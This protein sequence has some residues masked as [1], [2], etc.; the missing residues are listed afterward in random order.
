VFRWYCVRVFVLGPAELDAACGLLLPGGCT[1]V[2]VGPGLKAQMEC[3]GMDQNRVRRDLNTE[4]RRTSYKCKK[5]E[6]PTWPA[7]AE[8][9]EE[10]ATQ[11]PL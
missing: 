1:R 5:E 11:W 2:G 10:Q 9:A 6:L 4:C 7:N 8:E 3:I